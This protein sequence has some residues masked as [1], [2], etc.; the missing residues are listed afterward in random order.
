MKFFIVGDEN[1]PAVVPELEFV[2]VVGVEVPPEVPHHV[3]LL[4]VGLFV[5]LTEKQL[6]RD[7][8]IIL[9]VLPV[10][11]GG[12]TTSFAVLVAVLYL[13]TGSFKQ[14]TKDRSEMLITRLSTEGLFIL[15]RNLKKVTSN[16]IFFRSS[17][18]FVPMATPAEFKKSNGS[19]LV[20]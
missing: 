10:E 14:K 6:P 16:G 17:K 1:S 15:Q 18:S 20:I 13:Y 5:L 12:P 9:L 11:V 8:A 19:R 7:L 4:G 2:V 3:D